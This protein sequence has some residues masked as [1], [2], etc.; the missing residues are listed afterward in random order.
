MSMIIYLRND[1]EARGRA[2][3]RNSSESVRRNKAKLADINL[4][5]EMLYGQQQR[6]LKPAV[7]VIITEASNEHLM[8]FFSLQKLHRELLVLF[9]SFC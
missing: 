4:Q 1:S 6:H 8:V 3:T 7:L 5:R 9:L 2:V